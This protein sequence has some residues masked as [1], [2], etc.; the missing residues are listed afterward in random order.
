MISWQGQM[1]V[2]VE[3]V[4]G[5]PVAV[6][7]YI[8]CQTG[9]SETTAERVP[10]EEARGTRWQYR[11]EKTGLDYTFTWEQWGTP[12]DIGEA[13]YYALGAISTQ[14]LIGTERRHTITPASSLPSFT[15]SLDRAV[16]ATPTFRGA[17]AKI[18]TLTFENT[19][20]D[21]LR[22]SIE[23]SLQQHAWA[24]AISPGDSDYETMRP[25]QFKDLAFSKGYN[26]ASPSSDTTIERLMLSIN[27]NLITDKVT[28]NGSDYIAALPEGILEVTGAFDR[29]FEDVADFNAFVADQQLDVLATWT[30]SSM[31]TNDFRLQIDC[32]NAR[33]TTHPL[34]PAAGTSERGMYTV[35][36]SAL[37]YTTDT[38]VLAVIL[39]NEETYS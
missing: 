26:G 15:M 36:F 34:P 27:N 9:N 38:R 22:L 39:D 11:N 28:A 25:L 30:G 21:V 3:S 4:Y 14:V 35:E 29:E 12:G 32:P 20:R 23:G 2:G 7:R 37:Y 19:A 16:T 8:P 24:A 31:G 13:I 17:G 10:S 5:T 33:I 1:G 18:N 6:T